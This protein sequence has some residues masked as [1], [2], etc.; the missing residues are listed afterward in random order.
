LKDPYDYMGADSTVPMLAK[1]DYSPLLLQLAPF[2]KSKESL[3]N[4]RWESWV[5]VM[6]FNQDSKK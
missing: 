1:A 4:A 2:D 3:K 5:T 6:S